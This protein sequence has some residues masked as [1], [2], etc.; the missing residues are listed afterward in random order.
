MVTVKFFAQLRE[1]VGVESVQASANDLAQLFVVLEQTL[2][3]EVCAQLRA[4]N[5]RVAVNQDIVSANTP[6]NDGDEVA[7]LPPVTGG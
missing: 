2:D 4:N 5:V 3:S 6:L 1:I 7:F